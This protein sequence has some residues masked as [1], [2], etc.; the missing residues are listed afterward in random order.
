MQYIALKTTNVKLVQIFLQYVNLP[1][2]LP[3]LSIKKTWYQKNKEKCAKY[4]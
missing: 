1:K 4:E 3:M 2:Q